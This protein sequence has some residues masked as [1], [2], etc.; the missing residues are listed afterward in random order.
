MRFNLE[1]SQ[2]IYEVKYSK[3]GHPSIYTYEYLYKD[4]LGRYFIHYEGGKCSEYAVKVGFSDY[5]KRSGNYYI[6]NSDISLW[7]HVSK[8]MQKRYPLDYEIID[9]ESERKDSLIFN[10]DFYIPEEKLPF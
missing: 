4:K 9:W 2:L 3:K 7:K 5:A 10:D 1:T 8:K 6:D